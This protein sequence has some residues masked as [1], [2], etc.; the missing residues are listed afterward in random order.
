M[1]KFIVGAV[2]S[3]VTLVTVNTFFNESIRSQDYQKITAREVSKVVLR[4]FHTLGVFSGYLIF[5]NRKAEQCA[6]I[7]PTA[8]R[9]YLVPRIIGS[10]ANGVIEKELDI[11]PAKFKIFTLKNGDII[12][13]YPI[14]SFT[15]DVKTS[16]GLSNKVNF[17]FEWLNFVAKDTCYVENED[18]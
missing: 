14:E 15:A 4:M 3:T 6:V 5:Y 12:F 10:S 2:I 17:R 9:R 11:T 1:R 13:A 18:E 16:S 8:S 7:P